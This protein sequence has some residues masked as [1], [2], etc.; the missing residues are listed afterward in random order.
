MH[1]NSL[2][3][4]PHENHTNNKK[5]AVHEVPACSVVVH[6]SIQMRKHSSPAGIILDPGDKRA[7]LVQ[8]LSFKDLTVWSEDRQDEQTINCR[9]LSSKREV[10]AEE[11]MIYAH[12]RGCN[13]GLREASRK[14]CFLNGNVTGPW[15]FKMCS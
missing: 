4:C 2:C 12:L 10:P 15:D 6:F 8:V 11:E 9:A 14:R 5:I 7:D 13:E 3:V 1:F